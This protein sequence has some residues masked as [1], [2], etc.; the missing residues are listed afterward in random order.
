MVIEPT[1]RQY[2]NDQQ[3]NWA[4]ERLAETLGALGA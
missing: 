4:R 3:E 2:D 1:Y